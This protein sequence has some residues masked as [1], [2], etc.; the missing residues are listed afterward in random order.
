MSKSIECRVCGALVPTQEQAESIVC[1][2][3]VSE[4]MMSSFPSQ[5]K[6]HSRNNSAGYPKGWRFMKE[7]VHTN[8]TVFH[9]GVE[10]PELFGTLSPTTIVS[11]PKKSKA[12]KAQEHADLMR[13]YA[14]LKKQLKKE[15]RK[16]VIKKLESKLKK[17]QK[18]I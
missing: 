15:T 2:E 12:Q 13:E 5:A 1:W 10:Q 6:N 3:C 16:T 14:S 4:M 18:Q 17:L 9:K 8:G 7:F 11:K